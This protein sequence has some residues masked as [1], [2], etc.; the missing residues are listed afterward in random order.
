VCGFGIKARKEREN[1]ASIHEYSSKLTTDHGRPTT[2]EGP[3]K[4][5]N[6]ERPMENAYGRFHPCIM[7]DQERNG[8]VQ[9]WRR[10]IRQGCIGYL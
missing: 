3:L 9:R 8:G 7:F 10:A 2:G 6:D 1:S 4:M 5:T